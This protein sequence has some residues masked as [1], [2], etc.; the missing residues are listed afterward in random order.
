V[1]PAE[2]IERLLRELAPQALGALARSHRDF[3]ACED[4]LQEALLAAAQQWPRDGVPQHP[5]GW[6]VAVATR[7]LID[8]R[9][10]EVARRR[11]EEAQAHEPA[12]GPRST[13]TTRSRCW[14]C[15]AT[16]R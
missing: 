9:R 7:R 14:R 4:A 13:P 1:S 8:E 12:P 15:A 2:D 5:R 16:R 3:A 10:S 6:L 11:R